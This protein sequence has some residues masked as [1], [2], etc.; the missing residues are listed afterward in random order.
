MK[1]KMRTMEV[2]WVLDCPIEGK[3]VCCG[4]EM[5]GAR[6]VVGNILVDG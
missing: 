6:G 5:E 4:G 1:M 2:L 3:R